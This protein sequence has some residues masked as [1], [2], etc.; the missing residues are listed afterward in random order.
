[1]YIYSIFVFGVIKGKKGNLYGIF[2]K[3]MGDAQLQVLKKYH[4]TTVWAYCG[5]IKFRGAIFVDCLSFT[6]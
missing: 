3:M 5:I 1:M 2:A 6:S 4:F